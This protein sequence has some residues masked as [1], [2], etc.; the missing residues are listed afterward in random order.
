MALLDRAPELMILSPLPANVRARKLT[1]V[2]AMSPL[3]ERGREGRRPAAG[4]RHVV[5]KYLSPPLPRDGLFGTDAPLWPDPVPYGGVRTGCLLGPPELLRDMSTPAGDVPHQQHCG[6][7]L[8]A[9][10]MFS[11]V[12]DD[13]QRNDDEPPEIDYC[14]TAPAD[15][16]S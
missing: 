11:D 8:L 15:I 2:S 14:Q 6:N 13:A 16:D 4:A 7:F 9:F 1:R 10:L 3:A 12:I 5:Q